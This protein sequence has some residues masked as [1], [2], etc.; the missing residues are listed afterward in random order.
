MRVHGD[1]E[2]S[3]LS[4]NFFSDVYVMSWHNTEKKDYP[5]SS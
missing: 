5:D 4:H 3:Q 1:I 2:D